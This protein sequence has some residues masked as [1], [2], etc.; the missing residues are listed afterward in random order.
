MCIENPA[1]IEW[2]WFIML[3]ELQNYKYF[4][5]Y[6]SCSQCVDFYV[7]WKH[8]STPNGQVL[9]MEMVLEMTGVWGEVGFVAKP[10]SN[11]QKNQK[12]FPKSG[13]AIGRLNMDRPGD[14]LK[15]PVSV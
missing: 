8:V 4:V 6:L 3:N 5:L 2:T 7:T 14:G 9:E 13:N 12:V 10:S 11:D 15:F 1:L